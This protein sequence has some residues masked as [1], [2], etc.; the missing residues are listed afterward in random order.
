MELLK[1]KNTIINLDNFDYIN[2]TKK[3]IYFEKALP[4]IAPSVVVTTDKKAPYTNDIIVDKD[5]F[6]SVKIA[7]EKKSYVAV[8]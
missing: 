7:L 6:E 8:L 5:E 3:Y 4:E 2:I 1:I